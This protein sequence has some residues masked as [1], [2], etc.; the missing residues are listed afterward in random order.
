MGELDMEASNKLA[1]QLERLEAC[2]LSGMGFEARVRHQQRVDD[3]RAQLARELPARCS[4]SSCDKPLITV[5]EPVG[6]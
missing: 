3:L 1:S 6:E 5:G 2:D 4:E